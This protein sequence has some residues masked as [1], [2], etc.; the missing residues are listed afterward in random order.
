MSS[1]SVIA[2]ETLMGID[3]I[4]IIDL[5]MAMLGKIIS[6]RCHAGRLKYVFHIRKHNIVALMFL[7]TYVDISKISQM[8]NLPFITNILPL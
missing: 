3:R 5:D 2:T 7:F 4:L 6:Y 8:A 1:S